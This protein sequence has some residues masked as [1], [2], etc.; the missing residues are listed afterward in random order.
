MLVSVDREV[1]VCVWRK[2]HST[3]T[4]WKLWSALPQR[5]IF[6]GKITGDESLPLNV[7]RKKGLD[8]VPKHFGGHKVV[9]FSARCL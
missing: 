3:N 7:R 6:E 5:L 1:D 9:V 8:K 4:T 2:A